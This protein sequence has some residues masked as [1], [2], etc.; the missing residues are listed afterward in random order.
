LYNP[1]W[2]GCAALLRA[3][4]LPEANPLRHRPQARLLRIK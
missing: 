1:W 4:R 2:R 3:L